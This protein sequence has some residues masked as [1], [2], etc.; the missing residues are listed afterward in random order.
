VLSLKFDRGK[1]LILALV[2]KGITKTMNRLC[3]RFLEYWIG[4]KFGA[5]PLPLP[6]SPLS[7]MEVG[8]RWRKKEDDYFAKMPLAD[9][10][11]IRRNLI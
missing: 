5:Q 2:S 9:F 8:R 7:S 6:L 11:T 10:E 3:N 1:K 4:V